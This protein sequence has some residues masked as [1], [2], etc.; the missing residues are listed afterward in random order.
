MHLTQIQD[1]VIGKAYAEETV[2]PHDVSR[3]L[4][5]ELDDVRAAFSDLVDRGLLE[6]A[7]GDTYRLTDEGRGVHQARESAERAEVVRDNPTWQR[8]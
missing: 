8:H 5:H 4:L 2:N 1:E 6:S 7:D 3:L